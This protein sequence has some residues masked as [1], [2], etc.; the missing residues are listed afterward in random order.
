MPEPQ[1]PL[2]KILEDGAVF[3]EQATAALSTWYGNFTRNTSSS[4]AN[5]TIKN[6]IRLITIVCMYCPR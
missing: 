5:M 3:Y 2:D 6:W 4:F 1:A